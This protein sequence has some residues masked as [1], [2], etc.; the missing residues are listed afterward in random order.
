MNLTIMGSRMI[1]PVRI[2]NPSKPDCRCLENDAGKSP[3]C[4]N[5]LHFECHRCTYPN[6]GDCRRHAPIAQAGSKEGWPR[7]QWPNVRRSDLCG[8]YEPRWRPATQEEL[9]AAEL[10]HDRLFEEIEI[11]IQANSV[12]PSTL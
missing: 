6:E 2:G 8:D 4:S 9:R 1:D 5:C 7:G 3:Q 12:P 10:R 11:G